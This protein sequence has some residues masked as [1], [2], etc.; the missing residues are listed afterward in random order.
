MPISEETL[1]EKCRKLFNVL[2][3]S[4]EPYV[5][6]PLRQPE[7]TKRYRKKQKDKMG[8]DDLCFVLD[9]VEKIDEA[10]FTQQVFVQ[11]L[12]EIARRL[13]TVQ[14]I[15]SIPKRISLQQTV[16]L[17]E[18]YLSVQSGGDRVLAVTS[19]LLETIGRRFNLFAIRRANINAPD[20]STGMVADIECVD[21]HGNVLLAVEVKDK[22]LTVSQIMDKLPS[23][24]AKRVSEILFIAQKGIDKNEIEGIT[25]LVSREF[26][27]GQNIYVFNLVRFAESL[28][29]LIGES[30][31]RDFLE[32]VGMHLENFGSA[33]L[34][35]KAWAALLSQI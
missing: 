3:G 33:L 14:I 26:S 5:N 12:I 30:G 2:G 34:H 31:R 15:Y 19:S 21:P 9:E 6:N 13:N 24:R 8:W 16:S 23:L 32:I 25:I 20:V 35:R 28:L 1:L 29:A 22:E 18:K 7:I 27:S 17:I 11:V 10:S 4:S